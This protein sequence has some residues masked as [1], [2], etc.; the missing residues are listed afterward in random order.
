MAAVLLFWDWNE[1]DAGNGQNL[2]VPP[3]VLM[4]V[5]AP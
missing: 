1:P 4:A 2:L 3:P 5:T